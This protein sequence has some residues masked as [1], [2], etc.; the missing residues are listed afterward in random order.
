M[1]IPTTFLNAVNIQ[2]WDDE[3]QVIV[4]LQII[5]DY[6]RIG[7]FTNEDFKKSLE[8]KIAQENAD[9]SNHEIYG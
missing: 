3:S 9:L 8:N 4:L 2:C 1:T 6:R 5:D 7:L